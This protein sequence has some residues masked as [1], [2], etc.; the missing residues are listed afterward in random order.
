MTELEHRFVELVP[1]D[2]EDRV[3]Y[4]SIR[5]RTAIHKCVCGCGNK[6]VT[7]LSPTDWRLIFNGK[8]I[9][10]EPSIGNNNFP[11][12]SHYWIVNNKIEW[13]TKLTKG[14]VRAGRKLNKLR[15]INYY[16]SLSKNNGKIACTKDPWWKLKWLFN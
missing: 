3:I 10:L 13:A 8:S 11:C 12:E 4:I 16:T 6:T 14:E 9:S 2:L 15:K 7:P 1:K 5:F